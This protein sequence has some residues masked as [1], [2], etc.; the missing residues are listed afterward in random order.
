MSFYKKTVLI[1]HV[2]DAEGP[3]YESLEA[4]FERLYELFKIDIEPTK[5]NLELLKQGKME[6]G[7][8]KI[9]KKIQ[10]ILNSHLSNYNET[11]DQIDKML[12]KI[13]SNSFRYE[14]PDSYG[15]GWVF[16]WH[17][18]DHIGYDYNPR[19]RDIGYHNI[20]DFYTSKLKEFSGSNDAI[21][22]HFHPMSIFKEA[23]RCATSY[24]NSPELYQIL[25]RRLI[26]R[27][28]F[29]TVFHAG[30]YAERPDSN[31]F[32]EQWIPFDCSNVA[33]EDSSDLELTVDLRK[34]RF[35]DWRL[36]PSDWSIYHPSHDYYQLPGKCRRWIARALNV[37]NRTASI[38]Q[39]EMDKAFKRAEVLNTPVF[40]GV[41]G[42]D[43][44]DL[45]KE[46]NFTRSLI[47][48]SHQK[49][50]EVKFKY[51]EA[52][53]AFQAAL[54]PD[55]IEGEPLEFDLI[56]HP[57]TKDD[58]PYIEVTTQKGKVFG[59]QPF[60]A[61]KTKS[62]RYIHDNFDFDTSLTKWYYAFYANTLPIES[63]S[64]IAVG[65]NDKYGNVCIKSLSL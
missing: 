4:T 29:P 21:H 18:L 40:V 10:L 61:I 34:G 20:F 44:R 53:E 49:Y 19:R 43:Y 36:A 62:G 6:L 17:C 58:V 13:M 23:H 12:K 63:I 11:W 1:V 3:L 9:Q 28:W 37:M 59:P 51:C 45:A 16:N 35:G 7:N 22:W 25:C 15:G 38:N 31:C 60:L 27:N 2:I 41:S 5:K 33:M 65:A 47:K 54:W 48:I 57:A 24:V 8:K 56:L 14:M 32:L 42:H 39:Y 52:I 55:G 64:K 50:P 46:V 30:F 26:D